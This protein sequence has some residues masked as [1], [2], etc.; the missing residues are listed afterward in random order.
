MPSTVFM[1]YMDTTNGDYV[2]LDGEDYPVSTDYTF[3]LTDN[4]DEEPIDL[5]DEEFTIVNYSD[6][7]DTDDQVIINLVGNTCIK[8]VAGGYTHY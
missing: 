1:Y 8:V 6:V 5:L 7:I 3:T 2:K 4:P